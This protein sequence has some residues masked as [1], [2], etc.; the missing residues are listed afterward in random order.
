MYILRIGQSN[1]LIA[2]QE[3]QHQYTEKKKKKMQCLNSEI[4][5]TEMRLK[6]LQFLPN[7]SISLPKCT[8]NS[9]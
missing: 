8:N 4:L 2:L 9:N 7:I 1:Q 6:K 5:K 3:F